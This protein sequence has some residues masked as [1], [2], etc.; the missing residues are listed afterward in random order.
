MNNKQAGVMNTLAAQLWS[1]SD[2]G[3]KTKMEEHSMVQSKQPQ[4]SKSEAKR[5]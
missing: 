3:V 5:S 1:A 2:M 4:W